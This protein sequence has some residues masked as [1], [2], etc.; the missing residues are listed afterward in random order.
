MLLAW[1]FPE[2]LAKAAGGRGG[3][4]RYR[5]SNRRE[6]TLDS[7]DPL[8]KERDLAIASLT[9]KRI[10]WALRMDPDLL[11]KYSVDPENARAHRVYSRSSVSGA[12]LPVVLQRYLAGKDCAGVASSEELVG[13]IARDSAQ[14]PP[15]EVDAMLWDLAWVEQPQVGLMQSLA[16][17]VVTPR[18]SEFEASELAHIACAMVIAGI[19]DEDIFDELATAVTPRIC[20]LALDSEGGNLCSLLWA[21][22]EAGVSNTDLFAGLASRAFSEMRAFKPTVLSSVREVCFWS[23]HR[24]SSDA[25][26]SKRRT[27]HAG[28]KKGFASK[29]FF[30]ALSQV[31]VRSIA[32]IHPIT[33]VYLMW[34]YSKAGVYDQDLFDAVAENVGRQAKDLDRCGVTM[35]CWNYAYIGAENEEVYRQVKADCLRPE[36]MAEMAP[37]DTSCVL[38]AYAKAGVRDQELTNA[39]VDQSHGLLRDGL[40]QGCYRGPAKSLKRDIYIGDLSARDGAVDSFDVMN[41]GDMLVGLVE[42]QLAVPAKFLELVDEYVVRGL[43]QEDHLVERFVGYPRA[44]GVAKILHALAQMDAGSDRLLSVAGPYCLRRL[45]DLSSGDVISL[46]W[47]WAVRGPRSDATVADLHLRLRDNLV[48]RPRPGGVTKQQASSALEALRELGID[49]EELRRVLT[50]RLSHR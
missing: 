30:K 17:R 25:W 36:R 37:R 14:W 20:E 29:D 45:R 38:W 3:Q 28:G 15:T 9:G 31:V 33:C 10:F 22:T 49:D 44:K 2:L 12:D 46:L 41:I 21:Y 1:A 13:I 42:L 27:G 23:F 11:R 4:R 7:K 19:R 18:A 47:T 40:V 8:S 6:A 26:S 32:E 35:F 48:L 43:D 39:L 50:G 34:S 16:R 24:A 5:M